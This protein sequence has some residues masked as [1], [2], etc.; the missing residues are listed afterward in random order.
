MVH[1]LGY[2]AAERLS[3][4]PPEHKPSLARVQ[5]ITHYG[6]SNRGRELLALSCLSLYSRLFSL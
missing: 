4:I 3:Q 6:R 5:I 2:D 1:L